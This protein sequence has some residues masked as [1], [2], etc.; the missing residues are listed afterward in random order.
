MYSL[1]VGCTA[2]QDVLVVTPFVNIRGQAEDGPYPCPCCGFLT[3]DER[4]CFEISPVCFWE[5][6]DRD[7]RGAR[8]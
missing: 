8:Q 2:G 5:D 7:D 3:L 1:A 6:D 4:S